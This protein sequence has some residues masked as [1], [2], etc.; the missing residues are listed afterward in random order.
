MLTRR[1]AV[2]VMGGTA[3]YT[4]GGTMFLTGDWITIHAWR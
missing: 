3:P 4:D 1:S 2:V